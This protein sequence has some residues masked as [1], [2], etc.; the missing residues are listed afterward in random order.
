MMV[1]SAVRPVVRSLAASVHL[2]RGNSS[3]AAPLDDLQSKHVPPDLR[4]NRVPAPGLSFDA[5]NLE[6]VLKDVRRDWLSQL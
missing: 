2:L 1:R 3:V 5:P 6:V 4:Q